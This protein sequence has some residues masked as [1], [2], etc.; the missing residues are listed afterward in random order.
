MHLSPYLFCLTHQN[1]VTYIGFFK[2]PESAEPVC[3]LANNAVTRYRYQD[4]ACQ[5]KN[6][7]TLIEPESPEAAFHL[8]HRRMPLEISRPVC[9]NNNEMRGQT[10]IDVEVTIGTD[11]CGRGG[12][13][14]GRHAQ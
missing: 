11:K 2:C 14:A 5:N 6:R 13:G 12:V 1:T 3:Y 7:H 10:S 4:Y 8:W 9:F